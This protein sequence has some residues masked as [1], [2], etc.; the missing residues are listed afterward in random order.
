MGDDKKGGFKMK[1]FLVI[2][3]IV[4]I[5]IFFLLSMSEAQVKSSSPKEGDHH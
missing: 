4:F 5:A 1:Q 2:L 3:S